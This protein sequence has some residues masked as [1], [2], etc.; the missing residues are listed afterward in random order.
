MIGKTV[1]NYRILRKVGE[2][3][4]GEVYEADD[5]A[6]GRRVALKALRPDFAS[7]PKLLER[8]RAEAR[9]LAQLSHPNV[10][11]LFSLLEEEGRQFMVLEL[12]S[13]R[14][15]AQ[16]V[17]DSGRLD[18]KDAVPLFCQVLDGIGSAHDRGI[19]HRD[20]KGSNVMLGDDGI[21][22]VMD[23][24][25]A[26]ALGSHHL[27]RQGHMV[28]TLQ[29]MSPEQVRGRETD[30]RSDIYSLGILLYDLLTGRVPFQHTNDYELMRE[31]VSK[32]PPRPRDLVP[33]LPAAVEKVLL[34]ALEKEPG[35]RFAST[36][37]FR[38]ALEEAAGLWVAPL[39]SAPERRA[40]A[41]TAA[42]AAVEPDTRVLPS[43]DSEE[44]TRERGPLLAPPSTDDLVVPGS[45][46]GRARRLRLPRV[47]VL[48]LALLL[49]VGL[50]TARWWAGSTSAPPDAS[51]PVALEPRA[52]APEEPAAAVP[53]AA[54]ES[55]AAAAAHGEPAVPEAAEAGLHHEP[56]A[57]VAR[58]RA[59]APRHPRHPRHAGSR[60][61]T[62]TRKA[63]SAPAAPPPA[64]PAPPAQV[65]APSTGGEPGWVIR[66]Q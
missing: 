56:S 31:H 28:G 36:L 50:A 18:L 42:G 32:P 38:R 61:A 29:Y 16:L 10:A 35:R 44:T 30:E 7:Q 34:E 57:P 51:A 15:F 48:L 65:R 58:P 25:I 41:A 11:T 52:P 14:T 13:G 66:R 22:K 39:L 19:V 8:F 12:V 54:G 55:S 1:G 4:V 3:G 24:G 2:G 53:A 17:E 21:V 49:G 47:L 9:T 43:L 27:T 5:L 46:P 37:E 26:R 23:F 64:A 45:E 6:L 33:E 20:I 40:A 60:S 62:N 63:R 59:A